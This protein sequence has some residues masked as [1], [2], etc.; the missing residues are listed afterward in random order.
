MASWLFYGFILFLI[1][2]FS[3]S[4]SFISCSR[5]H[6]PL[7]SLW[8]HSFMISYCLVSISNHRFHSN[9]SFTS[10]LIDYSSSFIYS[11]TAFTSSSAFFIAICHLPQQLIPINLLSLP[12][13]THNFRCFKPIIIPHELKSKS[14]VFK[15]GASRTEWAKKKVLWKK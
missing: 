4:H 2:F 5:V 15:E 6:L 7:A 11:L 9:K 1:A 12:C 10:L 14:L 13:S 8:G 3:L